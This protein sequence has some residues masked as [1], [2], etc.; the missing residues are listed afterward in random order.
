[1]SEELCWTPLNRCFQ[2]QN[3]GHTDFIFFLKVSL[4]GKR[5]QTLII[6][7]TLIH[8][9]TGRGVTCISF[10]LYKHS[11][12]DMIVKFNWN[13]LTNK[14][15]QTVSLSLQKDV[16]F[17][18]FYIYRRISYFNIRCAYLQIFFVFLNLCFIVILYGPIS[19][20]CL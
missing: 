1:M 20:I 15:N 2:C 17:L 5:H 8:N 4:M 7:H 6:M 12:F 13:P 16:N 3:D 9:T 10:I 14:R 19:L 11:S 18:R